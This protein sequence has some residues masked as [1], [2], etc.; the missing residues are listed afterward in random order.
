MKL[1]HKKRNPRHKMVP[2]RNFY[3]CSTTKKPLIGIECYSVSRGVHGYWLTFFLVLDEEEENLNTTKKKKKKRKDLIADVLGKRKRSK[4]K[5]AA[6]KKKKAKTA[7]RQPDVGACKATHTKPIMAEPEKGL[8]PFN[9]AIFLFNAF[10]L[11]TKIHIVFLCNSNFI[12]FGQR[13]R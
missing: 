6:E 4:P 1:N 13:F 10:Y 12:N 7:E 9:H 11:V 2:R 8:L 5:A 3:L